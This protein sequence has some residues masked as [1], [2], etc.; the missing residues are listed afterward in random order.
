MDDTPQPTRRNFSAA[1]IH[2]IWAVMIASLG[3]PAI[4][5]LLMPAKIRRKSDWVEAA[6]VT[7]LIPQ[8]PLEIAFRRI[9][10]DGWRVIS[11]KSTAWVVKF[12]NSDVVAFAPQCTHLG[13]AY[14]W[15][16]RKTEFV[17]PC[18]NSVF[19]V[20]GKVQ[21]GPARRPLDRYQIKVDGKK[22]LLGP[23]QPSSTESA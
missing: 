22:L 2:G 1:A 9:R 6:D 5:Y 13:C 8:V 23:I 3:I 14:H 15:D 11:E 7:R 20:D 12:S 16:Q 19:S 21:A 17:C 10:V 4:A 18:H